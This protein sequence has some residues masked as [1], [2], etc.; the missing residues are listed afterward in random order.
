MSESGAILT[1]LKA[2]EKLIYHDQSY[3]IIPLKKLTKQS[4]IMRFFYGLFY[5]FWDARKALRCC[6]LTYLIISDYSIGFLFRASPFYG[7]AFFYGYAFL[8][9]AG[10]ASPLHQAQTTALDADSLKNH[11]IYASFYYN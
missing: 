7:C 10:S 1:R 5:C 4:K 8:P 11:F 6:G 2:I 9:P 3:S